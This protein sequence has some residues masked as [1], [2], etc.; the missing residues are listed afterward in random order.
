MVN[1]LA[2]TQVFLCLC[3]KVKFSKPQSSPDQLNDLQSYLVTFNKEIG[4]GG[5]PTGYT[6]GE[7]DG[8]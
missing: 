2:A 5:Q 1:R 3:L 4:H 7:I 8:N 6:I